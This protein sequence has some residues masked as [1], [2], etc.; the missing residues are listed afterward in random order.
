MG[1]SARVALIQARP[2]YYDLPATIEKALLLIAEAARRGSQLAVFGET[3]FPGYPAWLDCAIDYARWDHAPTKQLYA[4]LVRNSLALDS[5]EMRQLRESAK[6]Y[7]IALVLGLNER[8]VQGRGNRSLYN[9]LVV[10]DSDGAIRNHHRKLRPTYTEQLVWAQGDAAGLRAVD[11]AAGRV[12]GLICWEHWMPHARQAMHLSGEAIHIALWPQ[13][14]PM[15]QI[16]SRHYAF[17]GRC[18]VLAVG[19]IMPSAD[20]PPELQLA[21][22]MSG[23]ADALLLNGGSAIIALDGE[24]LVE[25]VY[26]EET[27]ITADLDLSKI[28]QEQMALDVTGHYAR[29]DVFDFAV[30]RRRL[31]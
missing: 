20:F 13:V 19:N 27:I 26:G 14:K 15:H 4:R 11:T 8:V 5:A 22:E 31:N 23:D 10:L 24:Y 16:A 9:S 12:G 1:D 30:K 2:V 6:K 18:F 7:E 17:E 28:A 3:F 25:P 21:P 29:D